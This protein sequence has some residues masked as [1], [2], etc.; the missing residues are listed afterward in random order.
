M[1]GAEVVQEV[2]DYRKLGPVDLIWH[3]EERFEELRAQGDVGVDVIVNPAG[4]DRV[5]RVATWRCVLN[6][7]A[8][9]YLRDGGNKGAVMWSIAAESFRHS[10]A[11]A[12]E[13]DDI[14]GKIIGALDRYIGNPRQS[15][16]DGTGENVDLSH[17]SATTLGYVVWI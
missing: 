11:R 5:V 2:P 15:M 7:L 13:E 3:L 1:G 4:E 8:K 6:Y 17:L 10:D 14:A 16:V 9:D 12:I